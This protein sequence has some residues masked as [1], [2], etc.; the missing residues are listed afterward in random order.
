MFL[1][2]STFVHPQQARTP[3][4]VA[5]FGALGPS[6][7]MLCTSKYTVANSFVQ[8]GTGVNPVR[9]PCR[10]PCYPLPSAPQPAAPARHAVPS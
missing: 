5:G 7:G 3:L 9:L 6:T 8:Q 1:G 2:S 10:V 4:P